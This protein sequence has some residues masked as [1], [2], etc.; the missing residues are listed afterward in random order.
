MDEPLK[1]LNE[2]NEWSLMD[3][4][5]LIRAVKDGVPIMEIAE[6]LM[7]REDEVVTKIAEL[8]LTHSGQEAL[9]KRQGW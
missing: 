4:V 9:Q 2:D 8:G 3:R 1:N 6:F 7:R 5:D